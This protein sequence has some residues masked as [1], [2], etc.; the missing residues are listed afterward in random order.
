MFNRLL[1]TTDGSVSSQMALPYAVQLAEMLGS[2]IVV[3]YVLL[4]QSESLAGRV[5]APE[6]RHELKQY[7]QQALDDALR[8][9]E[10]PARQVLKEAHDHDV[11][12]TIV[13]VAAEQEADLIVI[14]S[15]GHSCAEPGRGMMGSTAERVM[16]RAKTPVLLVRDSGAIQMLNH[17]QLSIG[18]R[19]DVA[20]LT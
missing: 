12:K 5:P 14:S 13:D 16:H 15:H 8:L 2:E 1:V 20:G 4:G 11:A 18:A 10:M 3:L 6:R 9:I 7:G 19:I 17:L